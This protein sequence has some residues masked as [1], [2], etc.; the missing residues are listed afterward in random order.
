MNKITLRPLAGITIGEKEINFGQTKHDVIGLLGNPDHVEES[1]IFYDNLN[2]RF[3]L[4]EDGLLEFIEC[5]GPYPE[6][7]I[8][9]IYGVNPFKLKDNELVDLLTDKNSGEIDGFEAPYC[10]SFLE[11]SVGIWRASVPA[12]IESIVAEMKNEGTY[13]ESKGLMDMDLEKTKYFWTVAVG[14]PDY[15]KI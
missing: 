6:N 2:V 15:Y 12:D 8:F 4:D 5:Q 1:Q 7:S 13:E 10:Y 9:D 3:D 14:K 11:I